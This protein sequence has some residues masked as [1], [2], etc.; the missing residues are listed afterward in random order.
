MHRQPLLRRALVVGASATIALLALAACTTPEPAETTPAAGGTD[1][2][3]LLAE[4]YAG[5]FQAPP[6][7][8]VE[9]T[10]DI[11][12]WHVSCGEAIVTCSAP[13]AA[14]VEAATA[15]GWEANICD[16]KLNPEGWGTC[17]RQGIAAG[18]DVITLIGVD[19]A[20]IAGPLSEAADAGIPTIGVGAND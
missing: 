9:V 12:L 17:I 15:I 13:A 19:C 6:T 16:G 11:S 8:P 3:A 10:E 18:A 20:P 14:A 4:A 1:S 2:A 5:N 7:E